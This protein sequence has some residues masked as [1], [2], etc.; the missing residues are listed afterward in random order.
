MNHFQFLCRWAFTA[1]VLNTA[2]IG[3]S[4]Q[5]SVTDLGPLDDLPGL[6]RS[7]INAINSS[8]QIVGINLADGQYRAFLY[9][10][11][12]WTNLGSLGGT[13]SAALSVNDAGLVVGR[14]LNSNS[15]NRP[16]LWTPGGSD[17]VGSNPQMKDLGTLGGNE[18]QADDINSSSQIAGYAQTSGGNP[19]DHAF[20]RSGGTNTD[21]HGIGGN[22]KNSYAAAINS[23]GRITGTLYDNAFNKWTPFFYNGATMTDLGDF[24][25]DFAIAVALNN[26]NHIVGYASTIGNQPSDYSDTAYR[27]SNGVVTV[28][29]ALGGNYS[30]AL[31]I[32]NSNVIVGGS[33]V[34][35]NDTVFHA[36]IY[37]GDTMTNL[38]D[39]LNE[40]GIGWVLYEGRAINDKGQIA[41][42]GT[43][44]GFKH[45]FLLNRVYPAPV[46]TRIQNTGDGFAL[47]FSS[48]A[49]VNYDVE[50]ATN[51]VAGGWTVLASNIVGSD[52]TITVTNLLPAVEPAGFY[53]IR[54]QTP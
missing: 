3:W 44:N 13:N 27:Y 39:M 50:S 20:R 31:G 42:V 37:S 22:T 6:N 19:S 32:N 12:T 10:N 9:S 46:I 48:V 30:Y 54:L 16:F 47:D 4:Q 36:F 18:G 28:L 25:Y 43:Y 26:S 49:G 34:D 52:G 41:G 17:G 45:G 2:A 40:S 51:L 33:T 29:G 11:G 15:L 5:Y 14:S 1:C 23:S 53:R 24:G 35:T 21:I 38:N 7:T 8:G